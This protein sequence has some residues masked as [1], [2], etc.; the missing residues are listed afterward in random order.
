MAWLETDRHGRLRIGFKYYDGLKCREPLGLQVSKRTRVDAERLSAT[1][2][3]ELSAG[4]FD[5]AKRFPNSGRVKALGLKQQAQCSKQTLREFAEAAWLPAKRLEVKRSTFVYYNEIY[6][7][8]IETAEI[9]KKLLSEIDDADINL[10]KLEIEAKRTPNREPLSTRR[11]NM[12]LDVLCQILRLAKRRGLTNDKLNRRSSV[13]K[14]RERGRGQPVYRRRGRESSEG[15]RRMERSLLTVCFFTGVRRGEALGL[16]WSGVFFDKE[17]ILVRRSLTRHGESSPKSKTSFR[18]VQML[19]RVREELLKQ[20]DRVKL[21]SEF[22]F[23][24]RGW[25][26]LNVNW[27]TKALWPRLVERAEVPY[28]PLIDL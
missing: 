3:L 17:R 22:V 21:R 5:Y 24:N 28:R 4:T 7:P 27:V 25:K 14:R 13:Q 10:W 16:R 8:H 20:R 26:A 23:P 9:G 2:Q 18:Y 19:P 1:I 6:K 12:S 11:K 15:L